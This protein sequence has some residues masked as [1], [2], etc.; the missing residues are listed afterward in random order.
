MAFQDLVC[1]AK[2]YFP[3]LKIKY[4]N[5]SWIMRF[6]SKLLISDNGFMTQYTT[7]IGDTIYF[8]SQKFIKCHPISSSVVLLHDLV[9]LHDQKRVGK[10]PFTLSYLFPQILVPICLLL[11]MIVNWKLMLPLTILCCLPIPAFFRMH[12]EK[13]A[14]LSS[15]YVLQS[16]GKRMRF[17]PH[18]ETRE[19]IFLQ[20]LYNG[21]YYMFPIHSLRKSF[22]DA[23]KRVEGGQRPYDDKFFDTLDDLVNYV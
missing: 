17:N 18:L 6:I 5:E 9:H 23:I 7:T 22:D 15:F 3:D 14:Y 21:D 10:I 12:W 20:Y 19:N 4:K 2:K 1:A 8:P 16:L 13:R 11:F